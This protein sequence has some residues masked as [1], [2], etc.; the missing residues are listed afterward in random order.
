MV[1]FNLAI[2][3]PLAFLALMMVGLYKRGINLMVLTIFHVMAHLI[4]D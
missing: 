4:H 1:K 2:L 3:N